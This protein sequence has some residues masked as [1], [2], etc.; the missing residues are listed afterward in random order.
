[1]NAPKEFFDNGMSQN[2]KGTEGMIA[3][4]L[5]GEVRTL[6][7]CDTVQVDDYSKYAMGRFSEEAKKAHRDAQ[8]PKDLEAAFRMGAEL[9]TKKD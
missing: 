1:M 3:R 2:Y 9:S 8:F 7:A 5:N 4:M 6:A